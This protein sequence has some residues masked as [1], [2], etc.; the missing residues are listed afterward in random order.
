MYEGAIVPRPRPLEAVWP[1]A[2]G[3]SGEGGNRAESS[4]STEQANGPSVSGPLG[5]LV[6]I[7]KN[8]KKAIYILENM[9]IHLKHVDHAKLCIDI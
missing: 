1:R 7:K 8:K 2:S 9:V 5:Y 3:G 4:C 6:A